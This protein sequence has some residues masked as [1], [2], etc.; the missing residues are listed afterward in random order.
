MAR[1]DRLRAEQE[2]IRSL[3]A[4]SQKDYFEKGKLS[5]ATYH[6]RIEKYS[7]MIRDL[8]RQIPLINEE[9]ARAKGLDWIKSQ[10]RKQNETS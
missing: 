9:L 2:V 8:E 4:K 5:E 1:L 10:R 7:E 3:I 6:A